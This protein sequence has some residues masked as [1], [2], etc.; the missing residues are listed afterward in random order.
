MKLLS[1]SLLCFFLSVVI[2]AGDVTAQQGR[3]IG[4]VV[5]MQTGLVWQQKTEQPMSWPE[6]VRYC[7]QL[8]L[9][10]SQDWRLPYKAELAGLIYNLQKSQS[11]D[12]STFPEPSEDLYWTLSQNEAIPDQA[13]AV[14]SNSGQA[15]AY[16]QHTNRFNARCLRE[17]VEALYLPLL[18]KWSAAWSAQDIDTY[19]SCYGSNFIPED[20]SSLQEWTALRKKRINAPQS[21]EVKLTNIRILSEA[22]SRAEIQFSQSYQANHYKDKTE[23]ILNLGVENGG[24]VIIGESTQI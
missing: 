23:K 1:V 6:A 3:E 8:N 21:I 4:V 18:T 12:V 9:T 5:D 11:F 16:P 7:N 19:L 13:W 17:T 20:G 22:G 10:G 14:H 24:V 15:V 2:F